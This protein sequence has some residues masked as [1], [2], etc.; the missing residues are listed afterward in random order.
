MDLFFH[1]LLP[2]VFQEFIIEIEIYETIL[3]YIYQVTDILIE[4]GK[5]NQIPVF[6]FLTE[7]DEN[8]LKLD[9]L[10]QD[11]KHV[12]GKIRLKNPQEIRVGK[13]K[14]KEVRFLFKI[15]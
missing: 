3:Y 12:N 4:G 1:F 13:E 15:P 11:S 7:I 8:W 5:G 6:H 14:P 10:L 9:Q 2:F